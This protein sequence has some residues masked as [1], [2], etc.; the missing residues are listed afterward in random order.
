MTIGEVARR[1]EVNP[2]TLRYYERRG[3][4][5]KPA[6]SRSGYRTYTQDAVARVRFIK[7]AQGLGFSLSEIEELL[8]LAHD[9]PGRCA[10][11]RALADE[12]IA[13]LDVRIAMLV[14]LKHSLERLVAT[15]GRP[16]ARRECPLLQAIEGGAAT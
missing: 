9:G 14:A 5:P 11:A 15:C 6:R 13:G 7:A 4:L 3:I 1:A 16:H 2:Q 8:R 12:K 10:A